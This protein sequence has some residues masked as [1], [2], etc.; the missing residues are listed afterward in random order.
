MLSSFYGGKHMTN[1]SVDKYS[2]KKSKNGYMWRVRFR[3]KDAYGKVHPYSKGMFPTK[4]QAQMHGIEKLRE[5]EGTSLASFK[6]T[7]LSEVWKI[8]LDLEG[9]NYAPNTLKDYTALFNGHIA[10]DLGKMPI[11]DINYIVLQHFFTEHEES[12]HERLNKMKV[13]INKCFQTALKGGLVSHNP[14]SDIKVGGWVSEKKDEYIS[15]DQFKQLEERVMCSNRLSF[16]QI[17]NRLMILRL[18]YYLG[19][20]IGEILG[21]KFSDIDWAARTISIQRQVTGSGGRSLLTD[22]LKTK[23]SRAE[24]PICDKLY[25]YLEDWREMSPFEFVICTDGGQILPR[26]TVENYFNRIPGFHLHM[27]R[28]SFCTNLYLAGVDQI[29]ASSLSRHGSVEVLNNIYVHPQDEKK[30][31]AVK[32]AFDF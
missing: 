13:V 21:L 5:L 8:H 31:E 30:R 14:T 16:F 4:K 2:V 10:P 27:L 29:T 24:L 22:R 6:E 15:P 19:L 20:R 25:D 28:H 3:Y 23:A 18:G 11:Q 12:S 1:I 32:K 9:K 7:T 26:R 17:E